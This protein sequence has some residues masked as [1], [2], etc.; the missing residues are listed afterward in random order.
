MG[1]GGAHLHNRVPVFNYRLLRVNRA[2]FAQIEE[3]MHDPVCKAVER[4]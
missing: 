1:L 2:I 3:L 4:A